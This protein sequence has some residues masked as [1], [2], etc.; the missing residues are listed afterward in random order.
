MENYSI[1]I[2]IIS[3][4]IS[5]LTF[6]LTKVKKGSI[7]MTKPTVIFMGPDG[8]GSN[9]KKIFIRTLL[10][11]TADNGRYVQ[12]MYIRLQRGESV[13]NFNIW[14]YDDNSGLVRG[15][16]LYISRTGLA[17]NHHFLMPRDG[18]KYEF[19]EGAYT[20][21]IFIEPIAGKP[22][23]L[24]E[25]MLSINKDQEKEMRNKGVGIYF[26]W[27]PNTQSYDSHT[28]IEKA[29]NKM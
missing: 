28:D 13:Q 2:S 16:G 9:H 22:H 1:F 14:V 12:N 23:K 19:L 5:G 17:C 18:S 20:L 4:L 21:Q 10:F 26:D 6:W 3:L 24:F 25:Q 11:S 27:A 8:Q 15:S 7:K 29:R